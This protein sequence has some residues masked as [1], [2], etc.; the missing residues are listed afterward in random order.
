MAKN[1]HLVK[2]LA[3]EQL[4]HEKEHEQE[5]APY[6][7]IPVRTMPQSGKHPHSEHGKYHSELSL[8]V[9]AHRYV[10][11]L[12]EPASECNMPASPEICE[13]MCHIRIDKVLRYP[14]AKYKANS[15]CHHGITHEI[16]QELE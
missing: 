5:Q 1:L 3:K 4:L 15:Y 14:E 2:Y 9:A 8:S 7:E 12:S 16:K 10:H 6:Q 13:G 11:I